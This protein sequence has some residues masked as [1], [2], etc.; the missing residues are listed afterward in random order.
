MARSL[1][2]QQFVQEINKNSIF[3]HCNPDDFITEDTERRERMK[4]A[5]EDRAARKEEVRL[6]EKKKKDQ[7]EEDYLFACQEQNRLYELNTNNYV[8]IPTIVGLIALI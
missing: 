4:K 6:S 7:E 8:S 3:G 2:D 5:A 1:L